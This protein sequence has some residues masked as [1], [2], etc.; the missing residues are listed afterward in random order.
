[1]TTEVNFYTASASLAGKEY[2]DVAAMKVVYQLEVSGEV[3]YNLLAERV[4]NAEAAELL[5]KNAVEE[6]QQRLKK[7]CCLFLFPM[8]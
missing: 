4:N 8:L 3:F 1:M 5:R 7:K 6:K 2:L